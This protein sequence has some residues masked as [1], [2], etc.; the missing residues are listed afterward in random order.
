MSRDIRKCVA[1]TKK[2][3]YGLSLASTTFK[4]KVGAGWPLGVAGD[5]TRILMAQY[6]IDVPIAYGLSIRE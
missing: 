5:V 4:S 3:V 6:Y 2:F 1:S